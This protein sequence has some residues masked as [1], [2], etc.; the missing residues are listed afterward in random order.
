MV[1]GRYCFNVIAKSKYLCGSSCVVSLDISLVMIHYH[2]SLVI[3]NSKHPRSSANI[4]GE[5]GKI[6]SNYNKTTFHYNL[7]KLSKATDHF[8]PEQVKYS[9]SLRGLD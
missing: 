1:V 2:F 8:L 9:N 4:R 5:G 3:S 6:F 7:A